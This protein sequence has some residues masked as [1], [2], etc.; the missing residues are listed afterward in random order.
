MARVSEHDVQHSA[1]FGSHS[2]EIT[3]QFRLLACMG[4]LSSAADI[5][6]FG[7]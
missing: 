2:R 1:L 7:H 3:G 5:G 4:G 6:A